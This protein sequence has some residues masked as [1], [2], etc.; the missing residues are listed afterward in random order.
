V[1]L[2]VY[3]VQEAISHQSQRRGS[4]CDARLEPQQDM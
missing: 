1:R 2:L 3:E 4:V